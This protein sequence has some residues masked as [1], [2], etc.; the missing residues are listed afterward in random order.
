M[1]WLILTVIKRTE[2]TITAENTIDGICLITHDD[3]YFLPTLSPVRQVTSIGSL[4]T[5]IY[6]R[7]TYGSFSPRQTPLQSAALVSDP[8]FVNVT[9]PT[10]LRSYVDIPS[11]HGTY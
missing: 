11:M 9:L 1:K 4:L 8:Y 5:C 6:Y 7:K 2:K 10:S 3:C